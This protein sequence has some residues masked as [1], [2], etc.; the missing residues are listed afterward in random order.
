MAS[1]E[2]DVLVLPEH[3]IAT[4]RR[5]NACNCTMRRGHYLE[6][7]R[8][9]DIAALRGASEEATGGSG[10]RRWRP[11]GSPLL[12]A[13]EDASVSSKPAALPSDFFIG[14]F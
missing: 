7:P 2:D 10:F 1:F 11:T 3:A 13:W 5:R 9:T 14:F 4:E 6:V 8:R 12:I